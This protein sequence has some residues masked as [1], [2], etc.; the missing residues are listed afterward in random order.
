LPLFI[1]F[2]IDNRLCTEADRCWLRVFFNLRL[3][4]LNI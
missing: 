3:I 4:C 1:L 2:E